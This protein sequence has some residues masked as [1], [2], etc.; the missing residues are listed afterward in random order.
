MTPSQAEQKERARKEA[1]K[2]LEHSAVDRLRESHMEEGIRRDA[3]VNASDL[4]RTKKVRDANNA[5][6]GE[7]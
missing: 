5:Y 7:E 1:I 3:A 2:H 6:A 4:G